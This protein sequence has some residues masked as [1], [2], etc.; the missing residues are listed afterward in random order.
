M[1]TDIALLSDLNEVKDSRVHE[2]LKAI[3]EAAVQESRNVQ[4]DRECNISIGKV[5]ILDEIIKDIET[6]YETAQKLRES[7]AKKST[8]INKAF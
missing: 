5:R 1:I 2:Y 4:T 8:N 6:A 7:Q 3:R